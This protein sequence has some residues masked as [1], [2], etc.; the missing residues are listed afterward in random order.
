MICIFTVFIFKV[1]FL[2]LPIW[3]VFLMIKQKNI[4]LI[5]ENECFFD[6]SKISYRYIL[7]K[8]KTWNDIARLMQIDGEF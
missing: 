8:D 7:L 5:Q 4:V 3:K 2:F 6:M 1:S